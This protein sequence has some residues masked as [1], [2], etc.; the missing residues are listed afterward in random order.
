MIIQRWTNKLTIDNQGNKRIEQV[1]H[2][3][4]VVT[5]VV[6]DGL[7]FFSSIYDWKENKS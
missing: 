3:V 6:G 4:V 7:L 1:Q 5:V 2:P